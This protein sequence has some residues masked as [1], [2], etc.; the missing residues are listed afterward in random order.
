MPGFSA[1]EL[2]TVFRRLQD[3]GWDAILV[4]GQAVNVWAHHYEKDTP[5]WRELRPYT[6]LDLDYYGGLAEARLA[7]RV[8]GA[9]GRL[10]T[11]GDPSPNAGVLQVSLADGRALL[12]DV[13]TG[14]FGLSAAELERTA[15]SL[16]GTAALSGVTLRV[17][18]PLLLLEA[19]AA[20]LRGLPQADRQDAKHLKIVILVVREWLKG[21]LGDPRVVFRAVERL[22]T[23]V[24]SPDGVQA[25]AR[26]IDLLKAVP[27]EEMR[28]APGFEPF[29]QQR[30]PQ[31][32]DKITRKRARHLEAIQEHNP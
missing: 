11:A 24:A 6:S 1:D 30:L 5:A 17:I 3:E 23:L 21:Q 31:L 25:F 22:A 29:F 4:G 20:A 10:N 28:A 7:M 27:M 19:K 8:L 18:H 14:V 16:S 9:T 12:V 2:T 13:L 26:G 15:V 32:I